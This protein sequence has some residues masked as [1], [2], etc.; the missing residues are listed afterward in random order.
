MN[1]TYTLFMNGTY[2]LFHQ[3]SKKTISKGE[4]TLERENFDWFLKQ[5]TFHLEAPIYQQQS[6]ETL[7]QK[8]KSF[9]NERFYC[10]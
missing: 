10:L 6:E 7:F 9:H 5:K 1:V 3:K 2:T 8:K 4:I